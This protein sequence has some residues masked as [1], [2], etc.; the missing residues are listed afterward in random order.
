MVGDSIQQC[1][2]HLLVAEDRWR[3]TEGQVCCDDHRGTLLE[4]RQQIEDQ[5]TTTFGE[6]QVAKFVQDHQLGIAR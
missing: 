3:L 1:R 4:V 2:C 6:W 5:L